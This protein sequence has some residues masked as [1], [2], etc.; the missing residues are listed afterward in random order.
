MDWRGSVTYRLV[1]GGTTGQL[2]RL[3]SSHRALEVVHAV[4][5]PKGGIKGFLGKVRHKSVAN[6]S[7]TLQGFP[8]MQPLGRGALTFWLIA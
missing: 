6:S 2:R 4:V 7:I 8:T 1:C 3:P 5:G